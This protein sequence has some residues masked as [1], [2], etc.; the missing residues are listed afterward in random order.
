MFSSSLNVFLGQSSDEETINDDG[1]NREEQSNSSNK[2][3]LL[4]SSV[5]DSLCDQVKNKHD[6]SLLTSLING[7]RAACHYGSEAAS[8]VDAVRCYKI[9]NSETFSKILIFTLGEADNLFREHLG[10]TNSRVKKETILE[11]KNTQKWK[12][13]KPLIKSYLRSCLFLLND[14]SETEI[15]RFALAQIRASIIFFAAFPSLQRRLIKACIRFTLIFLP[16][17]FC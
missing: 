8:N 7:Y 5:V 13:V 16:C 10:L 17:F 1:L 4:S 15:L 14:A 3:F 2:G 9:G 11:M 6:L 12:A